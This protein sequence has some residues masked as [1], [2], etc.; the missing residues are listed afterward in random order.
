MDDGVA[1]NYFLIKKKNYPSKW[2]RNVVQRIA[3]TV[4]T[5]SD[6]HKGG[7]VSTMGRSQ[8]L[9]NKEIHGILSKRWLD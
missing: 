4:H 7:R 8:M 9:G 1:A 2:K 3:T 5:V 6:L